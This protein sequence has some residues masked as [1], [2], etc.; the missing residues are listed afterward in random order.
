M[1]G[2]AQAITDSPDGF[3]DTVTQLAAKMVDMDIQG[4]ALDVIAQSVHGVLE[5]LGR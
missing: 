2:R 4:V 5:L 1:A 3:D